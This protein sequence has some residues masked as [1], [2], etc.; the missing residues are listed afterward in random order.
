M[1]HRIAIELAL[2]QAKS[3][4]RLLDQ[5]A[6]E[7]RSGLVFV[8]YRD[9]FEK[10]QGSVKSLPVIRSILDRL[11]R[12][13]ED[14]SG[15]VIWE[16]SRDG[17]RS[18]AAQAANA[19][20]L[21][22]LPEPQ[23]AT[24][25]RYTID[26]IVSVAKQQR[27]IAIAATAVG[28]GTPAILIGSDRAPGILN[29]AP[30]AAQA[31]HGIVAVGQDALVK[32]IKATGALKDNREFMMQAIAVINE[33]TTICCLNVAGQTIRLGGQFHLTGPEK[34]A[35]R[36]PN[37]PFHKWCRTATAL[38]PADSIDDNLTRT[39]RKAADDEIAARAKAKEDRLLFGGPV[40]SRSTRTR[41]RK[42]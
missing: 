25:A 34:Y 10:L 1:I 28:N 26:S 2:R 41:A 17:L 7:G 13:V 11:V 23:A 14:A 33:K 12:D 30:V 9:A 21:R 6:S 27:A 38:V 20:L 15:T 32:G 39:M 18:A 31:S 8:A 29:P 19:A 5:F 36:L 40:H 35:D 3:W 4:A 22:G 16:S 24:I 42:Q 37:P